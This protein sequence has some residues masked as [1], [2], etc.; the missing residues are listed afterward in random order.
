VRAH[1]LIVGYL[2]VGGGVYEHMLVVWLTREEVKHEA[3][4]IP[5]PTRLTGSPGIHF[6][7]KTNS[8]VLL[9]GAR[10]RTYP[11]EC[12]RSFGFSAT[13]D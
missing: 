10:V 8:F 1:H 5:R 12:Q 2:K 7:P 9:L 6:N 13:I 3:D 4:F 11:S